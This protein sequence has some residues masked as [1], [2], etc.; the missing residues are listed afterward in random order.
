MKHPVYICVRRE[1]RTAM[2][3]RGIPMMDCGGVHMNKLWTTF[4][5]IR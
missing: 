2:P 5:N 3:S 4:S 1:E